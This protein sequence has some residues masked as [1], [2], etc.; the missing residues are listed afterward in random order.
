M[1]QI[2]FKRAPR[3]SE[4]EDLKKSK[5]THADAPGESPLRGSPLGAC[6]VGEGEKSKLSQLLDLAAT[7][8]AGD[9]K[10]LLD[11]LALDQLV[12]SERNLADSRDVDMWLRSIGTALQAAL[13]GG[14][15]TAYPPM[16]LK[17][18]IGSLQNWEHVERFMHVAGL[19]E[20][21]VLK[22]QQAYNLLADLLVKHAIEI[23]GHT[24]APLGP[25]LVANCVGTV[26]ALFDRAFPGYLRAGMAGAVI[27]RLRR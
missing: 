26:G 21:T 16:V 4:A 10:Q 14:S 13:G 7:L 27:D 19:A 2:V 12:T 11:Q 8:S 24:G 1:K 18:T 22:R 9:R 3:R 5:S 20:L 6:S 15:G 25:K 23:A 17:R